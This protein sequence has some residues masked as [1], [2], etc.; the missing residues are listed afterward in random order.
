MDQIIM[1]VALAGFSLL[2]AT[3]CISYILRRTSGRTAWIE[4]L[5]A[6]GRVVGL[7]VLRG[8][9]ELDACVV[10]RLTSRGRET[11]FVPNGSEAPHPAYWKNYKETYLILPEPSLA[12]LEK[13]CDEREIEI[14][15]IYG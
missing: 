15:T 11:W 8:E 12:E 6:E 3:T 13:I 10:R 5:R 14:Q 7:E 4:Q 1:V 9:L 2:S